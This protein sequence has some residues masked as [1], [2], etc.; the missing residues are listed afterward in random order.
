[1]ATLRAVLESHPRLANLAAR[2]HAL[3]CLAQAHA[4]RGRPRS[5]TSAALN[6]DAGVGGRGT[7]RCPRVL[8]GGGFPRPL[9]DAVTERDKRK[10]WPARAT[11]PCERA[12]Q[13]VL[14]EV[15][16][17]EGDWDQAERLL[18]AALEQ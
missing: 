12:A 10:T 13:R 17:R 15:A 4:T 8:G 14:A 16:Y 3:L 1:M 5:S 7:A 11:T 18:A 6:A 2:V 9:R